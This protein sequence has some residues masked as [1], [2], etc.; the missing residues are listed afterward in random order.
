MLGMLTLPGIA[1][2]AQPRA[3]AAA[4]CP[5]RACCCPP[6]AAPAPC[7]GSDAASAPSVRCHHESPPAALAA[8]TMPA[9]VLPR[10]AAVVRHTE[11]DAPLTLE[12]ATR[13][14]FDRIESPPPRTVLNS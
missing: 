12:R 11:G 8:T 10:L 4:C 7:R 6:K 5:Q 3:D 14:G 9:L 2:L 1:P 13:V